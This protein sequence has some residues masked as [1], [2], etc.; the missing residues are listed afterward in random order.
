VHTDEPPVDDVVALSAFERMQMARVVNAVR[1]GNQQLLDQ[2]VR[3]LVETWSM[4]RL[5]SSV[6]YLGSQYLRFL[7]SVEELDF[8]S[9]PAVD[10]FVRRLCANLPAG[11]RPESD[12][13][14]DGLVMLSSGDTVDVQHRLRTDPLGALVNL[15]FTSAALVS[16]APVGAPGVVATLHGVAFSD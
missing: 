9:N 5:L 16:V 8:D 14:L 13:V 10:R 4:R 12:I 11:T 2:Q 7:A 6:H 15:L 1:G 3:E